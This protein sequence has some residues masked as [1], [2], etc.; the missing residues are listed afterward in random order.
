MLSPEFAKR[1]ISGD[2]LVSQAKGLS[3]VGFGRLEHSTFEFGKIVTGE[4][5]YVVSGLPAAVA[6]VNVH[7]RDWIQLRTL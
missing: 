5:D 7:R 2:L 3:Q 4:A 6:K 1:T